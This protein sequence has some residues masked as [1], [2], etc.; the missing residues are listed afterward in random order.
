MKLLCVR[1]TVLRNRRFLRRGARYSELRRLRRLCFALR[2]HI[3]LGNGNILYERKDIDLLFLDR[4]IIGPV[5]ADLV[6]DGA[7][8]ALPREPSARFEFE[9]RRRRQRIRIGLFTGDQPDR[10]AYDQTNCQ[11]CQS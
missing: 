1:L 3:D 10:T 9:L 8:H 4:R 7:F 2:A 5:D 6:A 11:H